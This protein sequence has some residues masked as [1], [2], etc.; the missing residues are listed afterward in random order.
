MR[1]ASTVEAAPARTAAWKRAVDL[2]L[3][4]LFALLAAPL[5]AFLALALL[6]VHRSNPFFAQ[7][8]PG[9]RGGTFRILKLRTLPQ[10]T[11]TYISKLDLDFDGMK[12]PWLCRI[13]RR[14]HLDELPQLFL[15]PLGSM[16]LVGPRPRLPDA[17]EEVDGRFDAVRRSVRPGCTGLWQI[18]VASHTVSTGAPRFDLA[19]IQNASTRLDLWILLRTVTTVVGLTKPVEIGDIPAWLLGPGLVAQPE[20]VFPAHAAPAEEPIRVPAPTAPPATAAHFVRSVSD[21]VPTHREST[22]R[23]VRTEIQESVPA[24]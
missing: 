17:V 3:G 7:S 23:P 13:L 6:V 8:R 4:S 9:Y 22:T 5:V 18:S 16:S 24:S 15:V 19:Y 20:I 11:P 12:L 10:T 1:F 21:H 2:T 14:T